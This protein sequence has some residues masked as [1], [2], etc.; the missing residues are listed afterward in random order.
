MNREC[1]I[2]GLPLMNDPIFSDQSHI[3]AAA[4]FHEMDIN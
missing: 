4:F 1:Y 3:C 2:Q